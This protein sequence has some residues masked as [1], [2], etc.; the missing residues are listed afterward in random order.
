MK[1]DG[2]SLVRAVASVD[3]RTECDGDGGGN[4]VVIVVAVV[5]DAVVA[6]NALTSAK[7]DDECC[8]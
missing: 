7:E 8:F 6:R 2:A 4:G 1:N 3:N 5:A